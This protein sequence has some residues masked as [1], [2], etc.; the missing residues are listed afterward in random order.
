MRFVSRSEVADRFRG[1]SVAIVGSGPSVL[2][3]TPGFVDAH[4]VVV[5]VN[6]YR[7][8]LP[9]GLRTDV[10]YSFY[11]ASIRKTADELLADGV[12]LCMN[13]CPDSKPIASEWHERLGKQTGIDFRYIFNSRRGWWPC[14]T[15]IPD[16]ATFLEKFALLDRHIPTTGFAAILDVLA[17]EPAAVY[18]TGFDFFTSGLHNVHERWHPGNPH[19]PIGHR[20]DMEMAWLAEAMKRYPL[21]IDRALRWA[22][23]GNKGAA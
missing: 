18:L 2:K 15:Y 8:S 17:C 4:Q 1:R 6:N 9:A 10:H 23:A 20:P 12:T 3:N 7:T 13:K 5:R 16:D 11:G 21:R 14:D 19:D 22:M